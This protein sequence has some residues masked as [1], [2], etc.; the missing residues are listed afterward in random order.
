P[1]EWRAFI[2]AAEGDE[3][4]SA[5]APLWRF[6]LLTASRI[7][8]MVGLRWSDISFERRVVAIR[9]K[10]TGTVKTLTLTPEMEKILKSV[11]PGIGAALVFPS[12]EGP[13]WGFFRLR[14]HFHRTV[15]LAGLTGAWTPH[16]IRHTAATWARKAGTPLDRIAKTLGHAGLNLVERYAHFSVEDLNPTLDAISAM[17]RRGGERTVNENLTNI[18]TGLTA[19]STR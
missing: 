19:S 9:Q 6:K 13:A 14:G 10:K 16:S 11:R 15:R 8:E 17:E 1:D 7:S 5:A 2:D 18:K 12:P 4:L 3:T